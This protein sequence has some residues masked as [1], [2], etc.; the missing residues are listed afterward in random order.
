VLIGTQMHLSEGES[1]CIFLTELASLAG[2]DFDAG[3]SGAWTGL[4]A[5]SSRVA[6]ELES[7]RVECEEVRVCQC[8]RGCLTLAFG[9]ITATPVRRAGHEGH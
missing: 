3:G 4:F 6:A 5:C 1:E 2:V 9:P 7:I 8:G